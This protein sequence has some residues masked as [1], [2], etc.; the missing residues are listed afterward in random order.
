MTGKF[1]GFGIISI[2]LVTYTYKC[3][4]KS[5][6]VIHPS[7][8]SYNWL[9]KKTDVSKLQIRSNISIMDILA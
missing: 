2:T 4:K 3:K 8:R 5:I 7:I 1:K 6:Y 9:N